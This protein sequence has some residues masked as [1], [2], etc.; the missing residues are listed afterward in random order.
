M[1]MATEPA[2]LVAQLPDGLR[3]PY[4]E[5]ATRWGRPSSSFT[6]SPTRCARSSSRFRTYRARSTRSR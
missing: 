4:M 5:W 2:V 1:T 3:V 6:A